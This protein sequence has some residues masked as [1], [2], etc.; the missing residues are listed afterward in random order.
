MRS[1]RIALAFGIAIAPL[2]ASGCSRATPAAP[3]CPRDA[4]DAS[5]AI[6]AAAQSSPDVALAR[7]L[8]DRWMAVH[9]AEDASWDWGDGTLMFAL[10][11]LHAVTGEAAYLEYA[12]RWLDP[13]IQAGYDIST[14]DRCPPALSAIAL[15]AQGCDPKYRA[16]ADDVVTYL[17]T[18]ALRTDDGGISHLGTLPTF[19]AT[20]W[21]DSL[22]MF[23]E[24]LIRRGEAWDDA[25]SLD[26]F[27]SQ[28]AIFARDMQDAA[29]GFFVHGYHWP[30][31][32][33]P[34]VF[35]AR[36][37]GWVLVSASD[38]LRVRAARGETDEAVRASFVRLASA[39]SAAQ[40]ASTGLFWT[41]VNRPGETY[42]ETSATALF[43]LGLAR[44]RR[45][46]VLDASVDPIVARAM[47]GLRSRITRDA[48]GRPIVTGV[49]GP[50]MVGQM[51]DYAAVPQVDDLHYGVGIAI[52]A[53]LEMAETH[54]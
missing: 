5:A 15:Y 29:A 14:S 4:D 16:V 36:G 42:L 30:G 51:K 11:R 26:L 53:L 38:Y 9:A 45:I 28:Y 23:G 35:W 2:G 13:H 47:D 41:V 12:R 6:T 50:T 34:G 17:D 25:Q 40:D 27:G 46:G 21:L 39:V 8:A 7:A 52:L 33:D 22:F 44:G 48:E 31:A 19:G 37:N 43:A 32:Q 24:V 3:T 18:R 54:R 20:L 10:T 1:I 49:S